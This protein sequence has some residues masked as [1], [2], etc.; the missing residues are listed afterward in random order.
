MTEQ[1][2]SGEKQVLQKKES[3]IFRNFIFAIIVL[4]IAGFFLVKQMRPDLI[5]KIYPQTSLS[6]DTSASQ[7]FTPDTKLIEDAL[8]KTYSFG[9]EPPL[10]SFA[11]KEKEEEIS[12]TIDPYEK[13]ITF[14]KPDASLLNP[15]L[16]SNLNEYRLYL[17]N[18]NKLITKFEVDK[19][20]DLELIKLKKQKVPLYIK[21]IISLLELYNKQLINNIT[22][23]NEAEPL[24]SKI[25]A[26]FVK[27]KKLPGHTEEQKND[28]EKMRENLSILADYIFSSEV[29]ENFINK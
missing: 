27:I 9:P 20:Y 14:E 16:K 17:A 28:K 1:T 10:L 19:R 22:I 6:G 3:K 24:D 2:K 4:F 13:I 11:P 25:L 15:E 5:Q 18:M 8:Q 29:Q 23:N 26:K 21:E 7:K 12:E